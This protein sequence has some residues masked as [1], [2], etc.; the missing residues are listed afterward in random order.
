MVTLTRK[1]QNCIS[2]S[3]IEVEYVVVVVNFTNIVWI[4]QLLKGVKEEITKLMILYCDNTSAINISKNLVMH[5]NIMH[6][7]INYHYLRKLVQEKEV[8]MGNI[9]TKEK[10]VDI[11]TKELPKDAHDYLKGKYPYQR[12]SKKYEKWHTSNKLIDICLHIDAVD[13]TLGAS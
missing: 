7:S 4:K 8:K 6:I 10:I 2:Q 9:K 1:K 11:F 3:T 13:L 5:T 12:L